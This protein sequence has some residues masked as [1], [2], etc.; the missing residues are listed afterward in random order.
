M[1]LRPWK[2]TYAVALVAAAQF[3]VIAALASGAVEV[4]VPDDVIRLDS[5]ESEIRKIHAQ[6]EQTGQAIRSL[7]QVSE[8]PVIGPRKIAAERAWRASQAFQ[9]NGDHLSNIRE[10]TRYL[11]LVQ[12]GE[13]QR[14]LVAQRQLAFSYEKAAVPEKSMR[15][16]LRYV[17]SF[18]SQT[19]STANHEDLVEVLR[20]VS[21]LMK[22]TGNSSR[23]ELRRLFAA[24]TSVSMPRLAKMHVLVLAARA[25]GSTGELDLAQKFLA[26]PTLD[27]APGPLDGDIL[28]LRGILHATSGRLDLS[29]SSFKAAVAVYGAKYSEKRDRARISLARVQVRKG[30]KDL[31]AAT[32]SAIDEFSPSYR[33]ALFESVYVM[34]DLDR[35]ADA[36]NQVA[37]FKKQY[38]S[39]DAD[40]RMKLS[41]MDAWLALKAHD[42]D[43]A[44]KAIASQRE[45]Y[46]EIL[47][48]A[49]QELAGAMPVDARGV[50][51]IY[52]KHVGLMDP[53]GEI[54][55]AWR[56]EHALE[57]Q[58]ASLGDDR[59]DIRQLFSTL[60][61]ANMAQ[62]NPSWI[63][64]TRALDILV[65]RHLGAGHRLVGLE[66]QMLLQRLKP[67][68]RQELSASEN[69]RN[70]LLGKY[71]Q[72]LARSEG[73]R[74]T[75]DLFD[76]TIR[77]ATVNG[78]LLAA[79][80][81]ISGIRFLE[82]I[83]VT[84]SGK[85]K[86]K[87]DS[88]AEGKSASA[89][90]VAQVSV[91]R[92]KI[93]RTMEIVRAQ[94][95][96]NLTEAGSHR[97]LRRLMAF[98]SMALF[99]EES[100]L[101]RSRNEVSDTAERLLFE[102]FERSW[103]LWQQ[104][105]KDTYQQLVQLDKNMKTELGRTVGELWQ[106]DDEAATAQDQVQSVRNRLALWV[107]T[108]RHAII[109]T[110]RERTTDRLETLDQWSA[111]IDAMRSETVRDDA[112]KEQLS[113]DAARQS[114]R[115]EVLNHQVGGAAT[116]LE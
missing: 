65:K 28:Y 106:R 42:W 13:S 77:L 93:Y 4:L 24:I 2:L 108:Q 103:R 19:E 50:E 37:I 12:T 46:K 34:I 100:V 95:I 70:A 78:R 74:R 52:M 8:Q 76:D 35:V 92:N 80:A 18:I 113:F 81:G 40:A 98:Y 17:G 97:E 68:E 56:M 69:R 116:W 88:S 71:P 63:N 111:D 115:D 36:R 99:D 82:H 110:V 67:A 107:G 60:G 85:E 89:G 58:A 10:L 38:G 114:A 9:E 55:R 44:Q 25:A 51:R 5:P 41:R 104:V 47:A 83:Q 43:G 3:M 57:G 1:N 59:G 87:M 23:V 84:D 101:R 62:I 27:G 66:R 20:L 79:D 30:Q 72:T 26:D 75:A 14:Y 86:S 11:N 7:P 64:T 53:P 22:A 94:Q 102:D 33:D 73:W 31:A 91:L 32:Y 105:A 109:E 21:R 48:F 96:E 29:L 54:D 6:L 112:G 39:D 49:S 16:A 15:A 90:F 61:R 45:V